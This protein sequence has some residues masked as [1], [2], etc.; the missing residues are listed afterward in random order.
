M[1]CAAGRAAS[2]LPLTDGE[3]ARAMA[4]LG[5]YEAAPR[6]AIAVS[7]GAD[8][9]ALCLLAHAWT[10]ARGGSLVALTVDHGLR[11]ASAAEAECVGRWLR[12]YGI[13]HAILR[14]EGEK[15]T[16]G[17]AAKARRA[18]YRLLAKYCRDHGIL[19]L[20]VGHHLHDQAETVVLRAA[21][22]S[23]ADGLAAMAGVVETDCVRI[24]RPFLGVPPQRLRACLEARGQGWIED[25]TNSDPI[26]ART[27][28][29]AALP[30]LA[31]CGWSPTALAKEARRNG[32]TRARHEHAVAELIA[33]CSR[34]HPAGFAVLD[35][36]TLG[37][38][39]AA[40]A[41]SALARLVVTIGGGAYPPAVAKLDR[42]HRRLI[43]GERSGGSLGRCIFGR[44]SR[45]R[46]GDHRLD[47]IVVCREERGLPE[48]KLLEPASVFDW[49][50]RFE[51][52]VGDAAASRLAG[53][54]LG[55]LG[56]DGWCEAVRR[57]PD[58]RKRGVPRAAALTLPALR[59]GSGLVAVPALNLRLEGAQG[60]G[61]PVLTTFR[62][63]RSLSGTGYFLA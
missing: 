23:G 22:G 37:A 53:L 1:G 61:L 15:P 16:S 44:L 60:A 55:P 20:L 12:A 19:H 52:R 14:W 25:P 5:P 18:R 50:G 48:E 41:R 59:D 32:A 8:S 9:M 51:V 47:R 42:L 28:I 30:G 6:L 4:A 62:P 11:A 54:R 36:V 49:D 58:L 2:I 7:G 43:G 35:A 17:L 10:R 57:D 46:D 34:L 3:F 27:R 31:A 56:S 29:R 21:R 26:F 38:A 39:S 63:R 13:E 45:S 40:V 33:R 24:I